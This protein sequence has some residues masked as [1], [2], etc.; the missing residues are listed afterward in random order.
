MK[1]VKLQ[2]K[3]YDCLYNIGGYCKKIKHDINGGYA[4]VCHCKDC[5]HFKKRWNNNQ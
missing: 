5:K 4:S 2:D 1:N 3:S